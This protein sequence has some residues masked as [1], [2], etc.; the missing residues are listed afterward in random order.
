MINIHISVTGHIWG[1][2]CN[3]SHSPVEINI[4][5]DNTLIQFDLGN[6]GGKRISRYY[7][8]LLLIYT[9]RNKRMGLS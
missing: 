1:V 8:I 9:V 3:E 2:H 6:W 5:S 4:M 7:N